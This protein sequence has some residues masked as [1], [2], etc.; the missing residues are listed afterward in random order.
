M[1]NIE[2]KIYPSQVFDVDP[3]LSL[4]YDLGDADAALLWDGLR[5]FNRETGP[6]LAYPPYDAWRLGMRNAQG[7]LCAGILCRRMLKSCFVELLYVSA[8]LRKAGI[9]SFLLEKAEA[10]AREAG[11]LFIHLD[12]FSFQAPE[13]YKRHGYQVYGVLDDYPDGYKRYYLKKTLAQT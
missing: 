6:M 3:S 1:D 9:G 10:A 2:I 11:C 12:T 13:F 5:A 8:A 7:E 4:D